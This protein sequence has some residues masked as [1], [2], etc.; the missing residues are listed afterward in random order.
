MYIRMAGV[1][2]LVLSGC[3]DVVFHFALYSIKVEGSMCF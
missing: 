3:I 1:L 2:M